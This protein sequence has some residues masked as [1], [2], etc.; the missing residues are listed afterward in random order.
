MTVTELIAALA[1]LRGA[2]ANDIRM[3]KGAGGTLNLA[4]DN[5]FIV[6]AARLGWQTSEPP[7]IYTLLKAIEFAHAQITIELFRDGESETAGH[8][9]AAVAGNNGTGASV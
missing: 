6:A 5:E 8:M 3:K 9:M 7:T 2:I 1:D 4:D